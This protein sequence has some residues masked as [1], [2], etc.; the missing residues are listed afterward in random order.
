[1]AGKT[2]FQFDFSNTGNTKRPEGVRKRILVLGDFSG[3]N[4][5]QPVLTSRK[6]HRV[7]VDDID[8]V[9]RHI[10][11]RL[12]IQWAEGDAEMPIEFLEFEDFHPDALYKRLPV[13]QKLR[14][15]RS[16]LENPSTYA[17]AAE[18]LMRGM[19]G[20]PALTESPATQADQA[21]SDD[22]NLFGKLLDG[23]VIRTGQAPQ[24]PLDTAQNLIRK[25]VEPHAVKGMDLDRQR[26][27]LSGIDDTIT[28]T[29]RSILHHPSFQALEA[30][31]RGLDWL[32]GAIEDGEE[33]QVSLLDVSMKELIQDLRAAEGRVDKTSICR[34]LT[35]SSLAVPGGEPWSLIVGN[36]LFGDNAVDLIL[37]EL[38][39]AISAGCGGLFIAG[40]HAKLLGCNSLAASSDASDWTPPLAEIAQNWQQLRK[41]QAAPYIGLALPRFMLRRP[42]GKKSNPTES[43]RFEEVQP[44][45]EH[46]SYLWGNSAFI[47]AS[48]IAREWQEGTEAEPGSLRDTGTL[49]FHIYGDG[50][51]QAIKPCAE[52]Y[53]NEKTAHVI[54][55]NGIIPVLSVR[56]QDRA[57]IPRIISIAES[58]AE[59]I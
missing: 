32:I 37:L 44:R 14:E 18:V 28:Q 20:S 9:L 27:L 21:T 33:I 2:Q 22:A 57:I 48:L 42:Y 46:E 38:L 47:C 1:M 58:Q 23:P 31:W 19:V 49:P 4:P 39:G 26:Q 52:A 51:G 40:A 13:F 25:I 7:D 24:P 56:N 55:E 12:P 3:E 54:L 8:A 34:L 29:M 11:P 43:F 16:R 36:Y 41:S 15:M 17:A 30:A 53:L 35:E 10:A 45:P 59:L 5:N 50:S 6:P